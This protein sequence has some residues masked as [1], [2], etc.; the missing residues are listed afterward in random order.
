MAFGFAA[1]L[2]VCTMSAVMS[3]MPSPM[4]AFTEL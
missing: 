1:P 4:Q 3:N 2:V